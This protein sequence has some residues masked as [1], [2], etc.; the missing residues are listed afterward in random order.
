MEKF[1]LN[2]YSR[3]AWNLNNLP[4]L[5]NSLLRYI[6]SDISGMTVPWIYV[7][8]IFSTF[9][10]HNEDHYT[11]SINYQ[12]FGHTKTWY[13]VPGDDAEKFEEAMR[14]AA[15]DLFETNPDLLFQLVTM[16]S[17]GSLKKEG[18]RVYACDQR[19]NEFVITYPKAY[20]AGFNQGFNLNEAVNFALPDWMPYGRESVQR[21]MHFSKIPVFSHDELIV[22]VAMH[23][24]ALTTALWLQDPMKY[25]MERELNNRNYLRKRF[26]GIKEKADDLTRTEAEYQC[27]KCSMYCYL[28]QVSAEGS[29]GI[30]CLQHAPKVFQRIPATKWTL[31]LRVTDEQLEV[32]KS[33]LLDR[34]SVPGNWQQRLMKVLTNSP[35]PPLK[36]LRAL[37]AEGE[38]ITTPLPEVE[39]L[40]RFVS[41]A[42]EWIE[43]AAV[44]TQRKPRRGD[45]VQNKRG[46]R[47]SGG[48]AGRSS[49]VLEDASPTV[50]RSPAHLMAMLA[51]VDHLPFEAPEIATLRD[52]IQKMSKVQLDANV[53][54]ARVRNHKAQK[55]EIVECEKVLSEAAQINVDIAAVDELAAYVAQ[56]KWLDEMDEIF[57]NFINLDE[58][59][60]LLTEGQKC[61]IPDTHHYVVDLKKRQCLGEAWEAQAMTLLRDM[62]QI[63]ISQLEALITTPN[64]VAV[65]PQLHVEAESLHQKA[66]ELE[67]AAAALLKADLGTDPRTFTKQALETRLVEARRIERTAVQ[68]RLSL[69][70]LPPIKAALEETEKWLQTLTDALNNAFHAARPEPVGKSGATIKVFCNQIEATAAR[71]DE[72][73]PTS[74]AGP[75]RHCVCRTKTAPTLGGEEGI[76]CSSCQ[77]LYHQLCIKVSPF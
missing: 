19:A 71:D 37:L 26:P 60:D 68:S 39:Q 16:M 63:S 36:T 38:R 32:M 43:G 66:K 73:V 77:T 67:S 50:D 29:Q 20:H 12:H 22:T 3:E 48:D 72:E 35:R 11:Y 58:V 6:K 64:E 17:P 54:L 46:G 75:R 23:N 30:A 47:S 2:K 18:V 27:Q 55:P 65:V 8:M 45:S 57:K 10:W 21:Y 56:R 33:K 4:I 52:V 53:I 31:H 44:Y 42:N 5:P 61:G 49:S 59:R 69:P 9:C 74:T 41:R 1:P 40:R 24:Q 25:M 76:Q 51:E 62:K 28:A 70:S 14:R 13:G 15:P 7:G 34:A